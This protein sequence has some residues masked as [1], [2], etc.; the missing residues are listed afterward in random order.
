MRS[1]AFLAALAAAVTLVGAFHLE[2]FESV[3][4]IP[5]GWTQDG[6][7]DSSTR[8][9]LRIALQMPDEEL[10]Q[11]TLYDIS[12]PDHESYGQHLNREE[13]RSLIKPK[14]E[15]AEGVLSWLKQSGVAASE[16][17][18]NNEWIN[19]YISVENAEL[20]LDANFNYFTQ[21]VDST[22]QKKIRTLKYSV[23]SEL[24]SHIAM[25]EPTTRFGQ[26][27]AEASAPFSIERYGVADHKAAVPYVPS[28][29]DVTACNAT[30]TP[31]CLRALYSVGDYMANPKVGSLLGVCGYLKQYAKYEALD[32]FFEKYAPYALDQNFTYVLINGGLSTQ[33]DTVNNDVEAN[34]DIQYAASLGYKQKIEYY[35]TGGLGELVPDLDQPDISNNQNEPYLE[36]LT[37]LLGRPNRELPQTIT[38]SYGEDEQSVPASYS[39]TV[40]NL[41]GQLG[42]RGVSVI[43]S[44]GDTGVGS[45]CQTN[46]GKNTTRF[47]PIFPAACPYVTSVGGTYHV[48]PEEAIYFSSGGFSDRFPRPAYQDSAV[49]EYLKI[50]GDRWKGLYN[51]KGRGFPDVSAQA[52]RFHVIEPGN[53]D[54]LV[55]GT[56]ASGPAFAGIVSLLNNARLSVGAKPL[57]FLNPWIYSKGKH[58]FTDIV[59][60]GST[61]CTGIDQY[62]GLPT[63]IVPYASWNATKGWDPVTGLGTPNFEKLLKSST[64][65]NKLWHIKKH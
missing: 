29:L 57:G 2:E 62:S 60:G 61:G 14:D 38:T 23:P 40:C 8:L 54:I 11:Q 50:L 46:D 1:P 5:R 58:G 35:S 41:F 6:T 39:K 44:S 15:A 3:Y 20:M 10:F 53:A 36:F 65:H 32:Q 47:L 30:I 24:S 37:Y 43:F 16:I 34:L 9:R 48:E 42:L 45:A 55:G 21:D 4:E 51:P 12:T 19:F 26:M 27:R 22:H 13:L 7:P 28:G 33:N 63:P 64:P 18:H 56:S 31:D 52:Y 17:E 59:N 25:I 49:R